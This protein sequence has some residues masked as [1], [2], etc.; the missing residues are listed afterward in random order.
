MTT[1]SWKLVYRYTYN[2]AVAGFPTFESADRYNK[3]YYVDTE[4]S[5]GQLCH[6]QEDYNEPYQKLDQNG[7]V[8]PYS[9]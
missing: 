6:V 1:K 3:K 9:W 8:I 2:V 5:L 7:D 4:G